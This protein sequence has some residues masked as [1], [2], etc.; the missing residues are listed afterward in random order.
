[1]QESRLSTSPTTLIQYAQAIDK[2]RDELNDAN[3]LTVMTLAL[4]CCDERETFS[5]WFRSPQ[6]RYHTLGI[7]SNLKDKAHLSPRRA[8]ADLAACSHVLQ[9][10][11]VFEIKPASAAPHLPEDFGP[12]TLTPLE[13][14]VVT[15][16]QRHQLT[17]FLD[18]LF[19]IQPSLAS[20]SRLRQWQAFWDLNI[21]GNSE[22]AKMTI[23][24][25]IR[26]SFR[27]FDRAGW[28]SKG[29]AKRGQ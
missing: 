18:A 4:A 12:E 10:F 26:S 20:A 16:A 15:L 23:G 9:A 24:R 17:S 3:A 5:Q 2:W 14:A 21:F 25:R 13:E 29:K 6:A 27:F 19:P 22:Q 11:N 7:L 28:W 8:L 1:M